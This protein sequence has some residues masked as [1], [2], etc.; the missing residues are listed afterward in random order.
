MKDTLRVNAGE[1]MVAA[2]VG[3]VIGVAAYL[4]V[5]EV[6]ARVGLPGLHW[7]P[8]D[9][10]PRASTIAVCLLGCP[11][12][13][14]VVGQFSARRAAL[15]PISVRR[16]GERKPP[17]IYGTLLLIPGVGVIGGYCVLS[18]MGRDPSGV[19]PVPCSFLSPCC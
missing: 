13:A 18:A 19:L 14:W 4:G 8:A 1:S 9:G 6:M 16:T 11:A 3:A 5:N 17:R 10:R 7:Y 15:S 12:L 2:F